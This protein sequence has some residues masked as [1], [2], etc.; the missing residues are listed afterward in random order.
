VEAKLATTAS[1]ELSAHTGPPT[2]LARTI[3]PLQMEE[4]AAKTSTAML[5]PSASQP[6]PETLPTLALAL[7]KPPTAAHLAPPTKKAH[8]DLVPAETRAST[9]SARPVPPNTLAKSP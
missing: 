9:A 7:L 2:P 5:D 3:S 4:P 1:P 6:I 8:K